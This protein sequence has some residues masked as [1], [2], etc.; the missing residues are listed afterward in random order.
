MSVSTV[1]KYSIA[2]SV[3]STRLLDSRLIVLAD[4]DILFPVESIHKPASQG[5]YV[6][7]YVSRFQVIRRLRNHLLSDK[8]AI[9]PLGTASGSTGEIQDD[10]S[11]FAGQAL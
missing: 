11:Y 1:K 6:L 10:H 3:D 9:H 2:S 7:L 8:D 5:T 4:H